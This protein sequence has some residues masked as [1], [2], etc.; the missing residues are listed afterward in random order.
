MEVKINNTAII[1]QFLNR[2]ITIEKSK[3]IGGGSH[4]TK[5]YDFDDQNDV[6]NLLDYTIKEIKIWYGDAYSPK[7]PVVN[8]IQ[9]T[10]KHI[11]EDKIIKTKENY[12]TKQLQG[13][14]IFKLDKGEYLSNINIRNGWIIDKL[15]LECNNGR[16][17]EVGGQ[18]GGPKKFEIPK[19]RVLVG[20]HGTYDTNLYTIGAYHI[21][22]ED[23]LSNLFLKKRLPFI[24]IRLRYK[25]RHDELEKLTKDLSDKGN[26]NDL[27][28]MA[29]AK[30]CCLPNRIFSDVILYTH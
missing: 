11:V 1:P 23:Y 22:E 21:S 8:G 6:E 9:I 4:T 30:L 26:L 15:S 12:G 19:N 28:E 27:P 10:Y 2:E 5:S 29:L 16:V 7:P 25:N 24:L 20:F 17:I 13:H 14:E 18:G 3:K